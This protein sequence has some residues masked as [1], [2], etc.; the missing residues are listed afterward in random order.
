MQEAK[1]SIGPP[2]HP[3]CSR[4][5][6]T[7]VIATVIDARSRDLGGFTVGRVLPSSAQRLVGPFIFFDHVRPAD[8]SPGQGIDVLPSRA[9]GLTVSVVVPVPP[10]CAS[11]KSG[12]ENGAGSRWGQAPSLGSG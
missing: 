10:D 5:P 12:H 4:G 1:L 2:V 8:F 6:A 11:D 7:S 9:T 3:V